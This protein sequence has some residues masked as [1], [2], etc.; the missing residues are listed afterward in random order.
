MTRVTWDEVDVRL[1]QTGIDRGML[2]V[3][4]DIKFACPWTGI[5]SFTENP[6]G[7]DTSSFFIDGRKHLNTPS[8]ENF[9]GT[10][11]AFW[12]PTL[13]FPCAGWDQL[14]TGLFAVDQPRASFSFSYRTMI[15]GAVKEIGSDYKI[16]IVLNATGQL[17]DFTHSTSTDISKPQTHSWTITTV[18]VSIPGK[19]AT[20]HIIFD[21]R[22][23]SPTG[24]RLLENILYGN[25]SYDPRLPTVDE[26]IYLL[27]VPDNT[28]SVDL[29]K[30]GKF[31]L[32]ASGTVFGPMGL[33]TI[34]KMSVQGTG[35][36]T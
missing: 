12:A 28:G 15:G 18:P 7:G 17:S 27:S 26:L 8:G 10:L 36:V 13:F 34:P 6:D 22:H 25:D 33:V 23:V 29:G 9:K 32:A 35:T 14:S 20:S 30:T 21:T 3:G 24:I 16:H 1:F 31:A 5:V 4:S 11:E 19:R 2:Y